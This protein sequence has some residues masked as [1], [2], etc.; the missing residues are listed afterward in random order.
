MACWVRLSAPRGAWGAEPRGCFRRFH[1]NPLLG[2]ET[3]S[4]V[5]SPLIKAISRG[6]TV[7]W[8]LAPLSTV[9]VTWFIVSFGH[10]GHGLVLQPQSLTSSM[11]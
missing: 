4:T 5:T 8:F 9:T 3:V 6:C 1:A 2:C 11:S 7:V 10:K